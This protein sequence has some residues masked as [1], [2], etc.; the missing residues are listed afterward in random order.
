[1]RYALMKSAGLAEYDVGGRTCPR[2]LRT[3]R[4]GRDT[5]M[6]PVRCLGKGEMDDVTLREAAAATMRNAVHGPEPFDTGRVVAV[7]EGEKR[8][9]E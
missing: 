8:F 3:N 4:T 6:P 2:L 9:A 1:M 5:S 7:R